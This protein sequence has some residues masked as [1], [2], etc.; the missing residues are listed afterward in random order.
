MLELG[1]QERALHRELG[2]YVSD[3]GVD[4]LVAVGPLAAELGEGFRGEV[5]AVP[6]AAAA[7]E[8]ADAIVRS[9]DVVLVKGSRGVGL[10]VVAERLLTGTVGS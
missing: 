8:A 3:A 2:P 4:V 9:G 7:A 6:D 10:E 5:H 1:P